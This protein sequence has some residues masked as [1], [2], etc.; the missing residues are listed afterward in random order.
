MTDLA[1]FFFSCP[2]LS[3]R[4]QNAIT[5]YPRVSRHN[6][7]KEDFQPD[8]SGTQ[9]A[10]KN[11]VYARL[12]KIENDRRPSLSHCPSFRLGCFDTSRVNPRRFARPFID[13]VLQNTIRGKQG[14]TMF[15]QSKK[16]S[17]S[18]A[19]LA[20]LRPTTVTLGYR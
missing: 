4:C 19:A 18:L 12:P 10:R 15:N 14:T 20:Y 5:I 7:A 16:T 13:R 3:I 17:I 6:R 9:H 11:L 2:H 1:F 8:F